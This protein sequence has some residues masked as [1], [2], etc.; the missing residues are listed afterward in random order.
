MELS[1]S[2]PTASA[3][4]PNDMML[5]DTSFRYISRKVPMTETGIAMPVIVVARESLRNPYRT[6]MAMM[7]PRIAA[8]LTS[9]TDEEINVDWS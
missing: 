2:I 4:P 8:F 5:S 7:P 6:M 9:A 3:M 1:T